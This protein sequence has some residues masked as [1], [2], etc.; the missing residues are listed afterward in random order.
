MTDNN[1]DERR[2]RSAE[3]IDH[4]L[5][6][7]KQLLALLFQISDLESA[8]LE[9][10]DRDVFDEFCQVLVDYIAAGHFGLYGR[11]SEGNERRKSVADL[12]IKI[13]PAIEQTT[14]VALAFNERF[15][16]GNDTMDFNGIEEILSNLAEAITNRIELEDQLIS[17]MLER[18]VPAEA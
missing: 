17:V 11:I 8:D 1:R 13:Y 9:E 14:E 16:P 3:L 18:S 10:S 5:K 2:G 15:D 6:E 12:A 4:M 7:R